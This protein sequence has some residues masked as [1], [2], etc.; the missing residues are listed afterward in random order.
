[1][2]SKTTSGLALGSG[3][4][5]SAD[6]SVRSDWGRLARYLNTHGM[7]VDLT[8]P[9]RQFAGGLANRNF[10]LV[11]NGEPSVLRRPPDGDLPPGAH[12]M[13]REHR[14]LSRLP[15]AL[16]FVPKGLHYCDDRSIIGVPF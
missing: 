11:V 15:N 14:I 12:D 7:S 10:L 2:V 6:D 16:P 3:R 13:A 8:Q 4:L 1:M 5:L 9:V